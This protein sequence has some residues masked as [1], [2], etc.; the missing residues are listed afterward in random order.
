MGSS[1]RVHDRAILDALEKMNPVVLNAVAWRI[2]RAG[3]DP[4]RGS[5]ANGR[6][7]PGGTVEVLYTSMER[8]GAL[9]EIG[10]R[11]TLEPVWPSRLQHEIHEIDVQTT[12]TLQFVEVASL[13]A[14][15][16]EVSRYESFDYTATQALAA[17][18]HFMEFDGLLVP[19]ARHNSQNLVIF[20]DRD[21]AAS[22]ECLSTQAVDWTAWRTRR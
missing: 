2:T 15:G 7:S 12:R 10:F 9:A 21:G 13:A 6:W 11:L 18:A 20:M 22:L 19:N 8:D 5:A 3:R 4:I 17:A 1:G 14:F 16:I